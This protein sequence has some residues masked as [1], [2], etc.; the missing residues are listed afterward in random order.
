MRSTT[1]M[2]A[3]AALLSGCGD[4]PDELTVTMQEYGDKWPIKADKAVLHCDQ[5]D[6]AYVDVDGEWYALNGGALRKGLP[7]ADQIRKDSSIVSMA[8]FVERAMAICEKNQ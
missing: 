6:V 8:D 5:P 3:T 4:A 1:V 2:I 7:R